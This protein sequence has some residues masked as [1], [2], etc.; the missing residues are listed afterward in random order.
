MILAFLAFLAGVVAL[1]GIA[2]TVSLYQLHASVPHTLV[3]YV[4]SETDPQYI[5]NLRFFVTEVRRQRDPSDYVF[6]L[7]GSGSPVPGGVPAL[8]GIRGRYLSHPNV[9]FDWGTYGWV[10]ESGH[11]D[12]AAYTH[13]IF[14]NSSVRGPFIPVHS[15][16][17]WSAALISQ[18]TA[19]V[20]LVGPT[21]S[22]EAVHV[23]GKVHDNPHVQSYVA[24]TD[25]TGLELLRGAGVFL[26]RTTIRDT[27]V[28]G[29]LGAS[30]AIIDA[31]YNLG[32]LMR[33]YANVDW[34]DRANW[35]CNSKLNPYMKHA[36]DGTTLEAHEVMFVKM[37]SYLLD[38]GIPYVEHAR[39]ATRWASET[40]GVASNAFVTDARRHRASNF[41]KGQARGLRC[42]DCRHYKAE[43]IDLPR[44]WTCLQ[45]FNHFLWSGELEG[46]KGWLGDGCDATPQGVQQYQVQPGEAMLASSVLPRRLRVL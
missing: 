46:R 20:K 36:Y 14:V 18:L 9:C 22:C 31:G 27:I 33:R 10:L 3:L 7:N 32:A 19:S 35:G 2:T 45:A 28:F 43:N 13:F 11:V 39:A 42:F 1:S 21:I 12:V 25:R 40:G 41:L 26:C 6:V 15:A 17:P 5:E 29:E 34:R 30:K 8:D 23:G 37:K 24:A 44:S 16:Q 4:F 38:R